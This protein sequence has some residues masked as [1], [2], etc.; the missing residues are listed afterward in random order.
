M[1]I[2]T[3]KAQVSTFA[4]PPMAVTPVEQEQWGISDGRRRSLANLKPFPKGVSGNPG[5]RPKGQSL[6]AELRRQAQEGNT[7]EELARVII[8]GA[9]AGKI[10]FLRLLFDRVD[11][12]LTKPVVLE[13]LPVDLNN[14]SDAELAAAIWAEKE[15]GAA[16]PTPH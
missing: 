1:A 2:V 12:L 9:R 10:D 8:Q 15:M 5:G 14:L 16:L 6:T 13:N 7:A 4:Q 11:G 3:E